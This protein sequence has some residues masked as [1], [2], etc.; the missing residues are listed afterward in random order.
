M[1]A[2]LLL[3]WVCFGAA[4]FVAE[5]LLLTR[6][7]EFVDLWRYVLR[8]HADRRPAVLTTAYAVVA[9]VIASAIVLGGY[10][11]LWPFRVRNFFAA[12]LAL[13]R[14]GCR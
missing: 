2:D 6:L 9:L 12:A 13:R 11:L 4:L 3:L 7:S 14:G 8:R 1:T 5:L 10:C